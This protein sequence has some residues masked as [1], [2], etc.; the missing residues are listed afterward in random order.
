MPFSSNHSGGPS[1]GGSTVEAPPPRGDTSRPRDGGRPVTLVDGGPVDSGSP[2]AG[3]PNNP[4][5]DM[6]VPYDAGTIPLPTNCPGITELPV[7]GFVTGD[8]SSGDNDFEGSCTAGNVDDQV[9]GFTTPGRLESLSVYTRGSEYDT[10]LY[11]YEGECRNSRELECNDDE[12]QATL[13]SALELQNLS[14]GAYAVVVD[15]WN[16]PWDG[17]TGEDEGYFELEVM[18]VIAS[19]EVCDPQKPFLFCAQGPC[20]PDPQGVPRCP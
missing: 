11:I 3:V 8:T 19:G 18:G 16:D 1:Y 17:I 4:P 10:I 6:G 15:G 13:T 7:S 12:S 5:T 20:A 14:A 2:D 9:F